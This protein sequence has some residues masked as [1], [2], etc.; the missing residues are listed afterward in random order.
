MSRIAA[1]KKPGGAGLFLKLALDYLIVIF[2][3][4]YSPVILRMLG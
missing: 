4:M 2:R 1:K 3:V